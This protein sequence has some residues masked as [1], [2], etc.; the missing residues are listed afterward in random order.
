MAKFYRDMGAPDT[1]K[2]FPTPHICMRCDL[3]VRRVTIGLEIKES[4]ETN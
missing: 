3:D 1:L 2:T 4:P